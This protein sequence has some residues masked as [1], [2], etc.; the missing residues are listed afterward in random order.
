M[1]MSDMTLDATAA[2]LAV[3]GTTTMRWKVR[4]TT[5]AVRYTRTSDR[6]WTFTFLTD[7]ATTGSS[8]YCRRG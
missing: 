8:N 3:G 2:S 5:Y 7:D 4:A 1:R 6:C